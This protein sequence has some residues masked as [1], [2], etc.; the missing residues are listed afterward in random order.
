MT[1]VEIIVVLSII[2]IVA[3]VAVPSLAGVFDVQQRSAALEMAR[4]YRFLLS[5]A[6]L[7]NVTFRVAFDLD[8]QTWKV[9]VGDP[10]SL[11]F[12]TVEEMEAWQ[13]EQ[14]K[15]RDRFKSKEDVAA[16]EDADVMGRFADLSFPGIDSAGVL[17][18]NCVFAWVYTAQYPEPVRPS[19]EAVE[20]GEHRVAY[21]YVYPNG[22]A[23]YTLV[24]IVD[25]DDR[26]DGYTVEV[27]PLS[28][29]TRVDGDIKEPGESMSW[30]PDEA[31]TIR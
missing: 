30:L 24:R 15:N 4:M 27:E 29:E 14:E 25:E 19:E 5:E 1:L 23:D 17:P 2:G 7:R 31:P 28:G 8:G 22:T 11:V 26:E 20:E 9:E 10:D 16:E 12:G 18:G 13:K 6:A 21:S 3:A